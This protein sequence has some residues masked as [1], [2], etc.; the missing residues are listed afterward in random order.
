MELNIRSKAKLNNGVEIPYLGLG[1]YNILGK[2][3]LSV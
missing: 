1:T 3:K 2:K